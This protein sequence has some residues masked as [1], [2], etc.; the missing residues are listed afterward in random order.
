LPSKATAGT[1]TMRL[2]SP[3]SSTPDGEC[4]ETLCRIF[5]VFV[6]PGC[7]RASRAVDNG[8]P[9]AATVADCSDA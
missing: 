7:A 6:S 5:R 9:R 1:A 3:A 2:N 8:P 4:T